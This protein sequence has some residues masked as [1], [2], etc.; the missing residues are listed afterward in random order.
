MSTPQT[1]LL[2][3]I[4]GSTIFLGLPAGRMRSDSTK[5]KTFLTGISAGILVFLLFDILSHATEPLES[6]VNTVRETHHGVGHLIATG[7]IYTG[8]I[9]VGLMGLLYVSRMWRNRRAPAGLGPGA[10]AIAE[11]DATPARE[12]ELLHLGMSIALGIGLH[13]F[14]EGLAIGQAAHANKVSLAL[15][16]VIGFGLHNAT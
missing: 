1:V 12:H 6:A 11:A 9:A 7:A 4:A 16:L 13:N 5:L 2:G 10:M 8:G 14:S 3:A 15:L